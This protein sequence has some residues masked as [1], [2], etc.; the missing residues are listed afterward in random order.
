MSR[1]RVLFT[2]QQI[3]ELKNN[4]F[5]LFVNESQIRFTVEFK[6]FLLAEREKNHTPWKDIFCK[7]GYSPE[8]LGI[9]R[10]YA[11]V[12]NIRKEAASPQGLHETISKKKLEKENERIQTQKAIRQLQEEVIRL[13][14]QIEFLKKIQMLKVL[15]EN[16][17]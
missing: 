16:E 1:I 5:T 3:E 2:P 17:E 10:M 8:T 7:A 6:K 15:E 13:Q 11:A 12:K 4:P 9:D 14:Q